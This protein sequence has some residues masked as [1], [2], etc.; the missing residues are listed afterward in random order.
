[1]KVIRALIFVLILFACTREDDY[2]SEG[3]ITGVDYTM[4]ACC[5]GWFITIDSLQYRIVSIPE[6]SGLDLNNATFPLAV[7]L[8]WKPEASGC[9]EVF[10]RI[11]VSRIKKR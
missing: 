8:D 2:M 11:T 3:T 9:G 10:K 5:G 4:C 7:Y 1:M 6:T